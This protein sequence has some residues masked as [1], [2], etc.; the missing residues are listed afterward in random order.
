M[1]LIQFRL[2]EFEVIQSPRYELEQQRHFSLQLLGLLSAEC[3]G[4]TKKKKK[5]QSSL[6]ARGVETMS[7]LNTAVHG[8]CWKS[9]LLVFSH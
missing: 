8:K 1:H 5:K 6:T 9:S 4:C 2:C 3:F 7:Q